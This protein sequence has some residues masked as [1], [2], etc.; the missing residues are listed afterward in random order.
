MTPNFVGTDWRE[1][2]STSALTE[3]VYLL[4]S[5]ER[6]ECGLVV[7][8]RRRIG[9]VSAT[10]TT[11]ATTTTAADTTFTTAVATTV[12]TTATTTSGGSLK[13]SVDLNEDFLLLLGLCLRYRRLRLMKKGVGTHPW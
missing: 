3:S 4:L 8:R 1:S 6:W 12:T 10:A 5:G 9:A 11:S 13:A 7:E 2:T